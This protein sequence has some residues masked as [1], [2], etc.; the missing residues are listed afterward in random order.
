[1]S[2][3]A[4]TPVVN[5]DYAYASE[6]RNRLQNSDSSGPSQE[7]CAGDLLPPQLDV[8]P[9]QLSSRHQRGIATGAR[10]LWRAEFAVV[11]CCGQRVNRFRPIK[12]KEL[13]MT[14]SP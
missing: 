2:D 1:M 9:A 7:A 13:P 12:D 5:N 4:T 6:S 11:G 8:K 10:A 3:A 14:D